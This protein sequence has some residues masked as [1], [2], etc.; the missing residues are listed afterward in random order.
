MRS[1][2]FHLPEVERTIVAPARHEDLV[3]SPIPFSIRLISPA[4]ALLMAHQ[5]P[6]ASSMK[7]R[8]LRLGQRAPDVHM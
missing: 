4:H 1:K 7:T 6:T 2:T 8:D 5:W 3:S